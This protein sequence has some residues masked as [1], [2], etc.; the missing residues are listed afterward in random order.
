MRL[1][2][3]ID[4]DWASNSTDKKCTSGGIFSIWSTI[5]SW[6]NRKQRLVTPSLTEAEYMVVSL[7]ACKAIWMRKLIMGLFKQMM[8]PT[9]I[10]CD[11]QSCIKLSENPVFHYR[12]K[13]IEIRDHL[14]RY[15]VQRATV[16]L[17]CI[18]TGVDNGYL[19]QGIDK[20]YFCLFQ[21]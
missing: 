2:G 18:P 11:N 17:P 4:V 12:S 6:Y 16:I 14:L 21:R 1:E 19:D 3:F 9:V 5:V 10:L 15:C 8:E 20:K 7:E 13:H